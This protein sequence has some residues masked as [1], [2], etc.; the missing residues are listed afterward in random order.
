MNEPVFPA[1]LSR[2]PGTLGASHTFSALPSQNFP[3]EPLAAFPS[4][5]ALQHYGDH[6]AARPAFGSFPGHANTPPALSGPS[7]LWYD[8]GPSG[9][10]RGE[11]EQHNHWDGGDGGYNNAAPSRGGE[12]TLE[13]I[14]IEELRRKF[15][16][17]DLAVKTLEAEIQVLER[18]PLEFADRVAQ[19]EEKL[20]DVGEGNVIRIRSHAMDRIAKATKADL[21]KEHEAGVAHKKE[22]LGDSELHDIGHTHATT[23][24]PPK[25]ALGKGFLPLDREHIYD[26]YIAKNKDRAKHPTVDE[27][28]YAGH[29]SRP[30]EET[31][32]VF[33]GAGGLLE[34]RRLVDAHEGGS[35]FHVSDHPTAVDL[36][37][38]HHAL[39]NRDRA[40]IREDLDP[41]DW[42]G[43]V[44]RNPWAKEPPPKEDVGFTMPSWMY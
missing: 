6:A 37:P 16:E 4:E 36:D 3:S 25:L 2:I 27:L 31:T 5:P 15:E 40:G 29:V 11:P 17:R 12:N 10:G 1:S 35:K 24:G 20:G 21:E 38:H 22:V 43:L 26:Q 28:H 44:K 9:H 19:L 7:V 39:H 32:V 33:V 18:A 41:V 42:L 23:G 30:F 14:S 34:R 13:H 8:D